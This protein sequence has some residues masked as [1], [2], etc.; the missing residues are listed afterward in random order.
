MEVPKDCQPCDL[1][2]EIFSPH[3]LH[4]PTF[5]EGRGAIHHLRSLISSVALLND[6][7][8][9]SKKDL[10]QTISVL[11]NG[12]TGESLEALHPFPQTLPDTPLPS[13]YS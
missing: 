10:V 8:I 5:R 2:I 11:L 1:R 6:P 3:P 12:S 4:P 13:G 9:K 7:C